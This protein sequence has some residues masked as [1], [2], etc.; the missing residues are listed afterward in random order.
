MGEYAIRNSD[1]EEIKIGTCE[2]MYYLRFDQ[3]DKITAVPNSLDPLIDSI[4]GQLRFR[5]PFADEIDNQPGDFDD[6]FRCVAL[7]CDYQ[8]EASADDPGTM[9]MHQHGLLLNI[10][11]YHGV[12]LPEVKEPMRAFWNGKGLFFAVSSLRG[13]YNPET[14]SLHLMPVVRC[15]VCRGQW[16]KRWSDVWEYLPID[17]RILLGNI[18]EHAEAIQKAESPQV[19]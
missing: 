18:K 8:D 16:R 1:R 5:L 15:T 17:M 6:P 19:A 11:C 12:R 4:A 2:D 14:K 3:R 7:P 10:P 9:Q 13:V